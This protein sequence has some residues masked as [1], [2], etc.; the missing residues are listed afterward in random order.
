MNNQPNNAIYGPKSGQKPPGTGA[1]KNSTTVNQPVASTPNAY[2]KTRV[3]A[4]SPAE[5]RLMLIEGAIR[6]TELARSGITEAHPENMFNGF[7]KARA[8]ITELISGLNPEAAPDL[9]ERLTSL[10]TFVFTR[11]VDA[12]SERSVEICDEVLQ[13]LRYEQ[14]TWTLLVASLVS[15]NESASTLDAMPP[16]SANTSSTETTGSSLP[17]AGRISAT[18]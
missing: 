18:G 6:F 13:L 5:L 14:E 15:E 11:L 17:T 1:P 16:L 9:C 12:S 3:M 4:A 2:L 10:Y 7:S 8:I